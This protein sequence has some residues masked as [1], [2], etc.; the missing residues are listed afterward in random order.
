MNTQKINRFL[1][2]NLFFYII[3]FFILF[4]MKYLYSKAD[5]EGLRWILGP[6]AGWVEV[7]SGIPFVYERGMGYAN[8]GLRFLIAPSCSGVQFLIITAAMLIFSFVHEAADFRPAGCRRD[9]EEESSSPSCP[10]HIYDNDVSVMSKSSPL[11]IGKGIC[12]I[13]ASLLLSYV[14]TV[15]VNGLRII[16]A[17]YL[18]SFFERIHAF[19]RFLTPDR[20]H[21]MIG[22]VV[23]FAALLTIHQLTRLLFH[24]NSGAD[25]KQTSAL[26]LRKCL[27]PLFWYFFLVLGIPF[28]NRAYDRSGKQF[29]EF[30][31]L[32]TLCCGFILLLYCLGALIRRQFPGRG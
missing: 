29:T 15:F 14:L 23:Y 10:G 32:V 8:H 11:R 6:T 18:P 5:C 24:K 4:G 31:L 19:G 13:A 20:L 16:A 26:V 25:R 3:G 17:I 1:R 2:Q 28:L 27:S 7:L 30:A 12:W 9:K 22:V 21:T